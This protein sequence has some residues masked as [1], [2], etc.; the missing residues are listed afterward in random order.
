MITGKP[1]LGQQQQLKLLLKD[2]LDVSLKG[3]G[4]DKKVSAKTK[5]QCI[6]SHKGRVKK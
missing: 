6:T 5:F 3:P 2:D 1:K 4:I